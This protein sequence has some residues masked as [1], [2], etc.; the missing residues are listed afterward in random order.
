MLLE[1]VNWALYETRNAPLYYRTILTTNFGPTEILL[2][3]QLFFSVSDDLGR[4][5]SPDV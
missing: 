3:F 5:L 4:I 1:T 2:V